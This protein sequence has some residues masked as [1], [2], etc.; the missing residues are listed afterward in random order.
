MRKVQ[1]VALAFVV[2]A[3]CLGGVA[4]LRNVFSE[5]VPRRAR[6]PRAERRHRLLGGPQRRP[7][8][9]GV[10]EPDGSGARQLT[11][12][13]NASETRMLSTS[14]S[15]AARWRSFAPVR[16]AP[17]SGS[18]ESTAKASGGSP[19]ADISAVA[20]VV[21]ARWRS[22]RVRGRGGR[23]GPHRV[24]RRLRAAVARRSARSRDR[25]HV[26]AGRR[27]DR[28]RRPE[29]G[30]RCAAQLRPVD[31]VGNRLWH[32]LARHHGRERSERVVS[33]VVLGRQP[34]PLLGPR[35]REHR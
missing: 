28:I 29:P 25:L 26:V 17:R 12:D 9:P 1:S 20:P 22:G 34:D 6:V 8:P 15:T 35:R 2:I 14:S 23:R 11:N 7:A 16:T 10:V 5:P 32:P 21:V 4:V 24:R 31:R 33:R 3:G 19:P 18:W 13:P 30:N 27:G